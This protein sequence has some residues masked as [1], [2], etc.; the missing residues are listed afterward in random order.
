MAKKTSIANSTEKQET[1]KFC[2]EKDEMTLLEFKH[3]YYTG[4]ED[5]DF[6]NILY[7]AELVD[8]KGLPT[9]KAIDN[10]LIYFKDGESNTDLDWEYYPQGRRLVVGEHEYLSEYLEFREYREQFS[11]L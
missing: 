8:K 4:Y 1:I 10:Q 5:K 9:P 3:W 2:L 7:R 6:F 11:L